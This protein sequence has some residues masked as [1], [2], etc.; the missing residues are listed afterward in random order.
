M[1]LITL[2]GLHKWKDKLDINN[3]D[4]PKSEWEDWDSNAKA[5]AAWSLGWPI[6]WMAL[7]AMLFW[8][9]VVLI[10]I[11]IGQLIK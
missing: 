1:F 3:Y 7:T 10:S 9:G 5:Y 8:K 6:I 2:I 4:G 11:K